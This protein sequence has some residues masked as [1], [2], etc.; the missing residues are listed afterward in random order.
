MTTIDPNKTRLLEY[1]RMEAHFV[2]EDALRIKYSILKVTK[3]YIWIISV[4]MLLVS[5]L[6]FLLPTPNEFLSPFAFIRLMLPTLGSLGIIVLVYAAVMEGLNRFSS[7]V[8]QGEITELPDP[9]GASIKA[10]VYELSDSMGIQREKIRFWKSINYAIYPSIEQ[11][12]DD[13]INMII[14]INFFLF[15]SQ[16]TEK[17]KAIFAH[18]L[19]HVLQNDTE[20]YLLAETFYNSIRVIVIPILFIQAVMLLISFFRVNS[21]TLDMGSVVEL[22]IYAGTSILFLQF[23]IRKYRAIKK[24]RKRSEHM[25]DLCAFIYADSKAILKVLEGLQPLKRRSLEKVHPDKNSRIDFLI[26]FESSFKPDD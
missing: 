22:V 24:L 3:I 7:S 25:A 21:F 18:E 1:Y 2:N 16:H 8:E 4:P 14:P 19:G 12:N 11:T 20:V 9:Y 15:H 6:Y 13:G 23:Y 26:N 10:M 17:S 5:L